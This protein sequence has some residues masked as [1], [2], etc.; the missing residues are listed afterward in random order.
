MQ[1]RRFISSFGQCLIK[2]TS[3]SKFKLNLM[4]TMRVADTP[5]EEQDCARMPGRPAVWMKRWIPAF[6]LILVWSFAATAEPASLTTL[7][8]VAAMTNE[9]ASQRQQVTFD[10]TITFYR[11]QV[12]DL[13]VQD[14]DSAIFVNPKVMR[15][16][17]PGDRIRV[18]GTMHPSFRP[19]VDATDMTLLGHGPLPKPNQPRFEQMIRAETDCKL[20]KVRALIQ[21]ADLVPNLQTAFSTTELNVLVDGGPA[22]VTI[23]SDDPKR[24]NDLLDSEVELTGV[25]SGLFDNK[26]QE[27]GILLHVQS[28]DEV[29]ILKRA[30]VDPWSLPNTPM[31]RILAGYQVSEQS[32]RQRVHGTITYYEPGAALVLQN[33]SRSVWVSTESWKPLEVG[34]VADAIGFPTVEK[35]FLTLSRAEVQEAPSQA[36]VSP[37]LFTWHQLALGGNDGEGHVFDLVSLEGAVV[38]EVRQA[39][40]DEYV[41]ESDGHLLSAFIRHPASSARIPLAPMLEIPV[42]TH[43]RVSG[44]CILTDANPFNGEVP[45]NI[46]M[47]N[48]SDIVVVARPPWLNVPHL[49]LIIGLLL[50]VVIVIGVRGWA[51]ERRVR[52][53]TAAL[54]YLERRRSR[55]L[56]AINGS[57]PL[58][59][60]I[61]Q[62]TEV[63]SYRLQGAPCWCEIRGGARF[64]N[65]PPD[66]RSLRVVQKEIPART[67]L[68]LGTM[69]TSCDALTKPRAEPL[70]A[71]GLGASLAALAI[72]TRRL[73]TDLLRRS[74]FDLLTDIENRFSMEK[75]LDALI[76]RARE[77]AGIFGLIYIDLDDF[78]QVNDRFG[79]QVGD[80]YLQQ[81]AA[82]MKRQLRP[83][84]I[85]ARLGGDEFAVLVPKV[86][87][88]TDVQEIA[89]RLER[90]FDEPFSVQGYVIAGSASVGI[91]LY[92]DD[93]STRD[94]LL[95]IS[96][97]AMYTAKHAHA[98]KKDIPAEQQEPE[99]PLESQK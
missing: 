75:H 4:W 74:E 64:G 50:C 77:T 87:I 69:F 70:E 84:D 16:L 86:R 35:G 57:T 5:H 6:A 36:P 15:K 10:A 8:A 67:G 95:R 61:E 96:D 23:N 21:S 41:L 7:Q 19:Y 81:A 92:P 99:V 78:K 28:L 60:I 82:R 29:K 55:I 24:L 31:D 2:A 90:C 58:A 59:E 54:A 56:E 71:L 46:L 73:Y 18:H 91:A 98:I 39:T 65:L 52:R 79:H 26:M 80:L 76:E 97:A 68:P 30:Q 85:L 25:Q 14:G 43:I 47:R 53:K 37:S 72:E 33:G 1:D 93:A 94:A 83:G 27:T 88:R 11:P 38:T 42:G 12:R 45:F 66:L 40:Q 62:I 48:V 13:F 44:I 3:R 32:E 17:I 51:L 34:A 63:V 20:V 9:E 49:I 22:E 89:V